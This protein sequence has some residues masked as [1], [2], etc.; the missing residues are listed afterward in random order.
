MWPTS[1]AR[2]RSSTKRWFKRYRRSRSEPLREPQMPS[3]HLS[4]E[5]LQKRLQDAQEGRR[6]V[7]AMRPTTRWLAAMA[8]RLLEENHLAERIRRSAL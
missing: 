6:E 5:E 7:L 3:P 4:T 8:E 1:S 2:D